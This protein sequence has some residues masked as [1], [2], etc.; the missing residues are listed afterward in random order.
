VV[1]GG[2]DGAAKIWDIASLKNLH[3][4]KWGSWVQS[5]AFSLDG[6]LLAT[7]GSSQW[8]QK[9]KGTTTAV[10]IW[11]GVTGE[12]LTDLRG[13][14]F[15][16]RVVHC[17][18]FSPDGQTLAAGNAREFTTRR[19]PVLLWEVPSGKLR[20]TFEGGMSFVYALQF[21]PDG[22]TLATGGIGPEENKS[23]SLKLWDVTTGKVKTEFKELEARVYSVAFSPDGKLLASGGGETK[24][25]K[26][27]TE[28]LLWDVSTGKRLATLRGHRGSVHGVQFSHDGKLLASAGGDPFFIKAELKLW[29]VKTLKEIVTLKG[30]KDLVGSVAFSPDDTMLASGSNDGT[31]RLWYLRDKPPAKDKPDR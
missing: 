18:A 23:P 13:D 26:D 7:G 17:V 12:K 28:L 4:L 14:P 24:N 3:V 21:S 19:C 27:I 30:H 5:V 25:G 8:L 29:D 11:K 1:S 10:G 9:D 6:R 16:T 15:I 2:S 20:R 22:K 31:V